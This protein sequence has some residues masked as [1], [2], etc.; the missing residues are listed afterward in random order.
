MKMGIGMQVENHTSRDSRE[1]KKFELRKSLGEGA[2]SPSLLILPESFSADFLNGIPENVIV[3]TFKACALGPGEDLSVAN[4]LSV[5]KKNCDER[6]CCAL[7]PSKVPTALGRVCLTIL[8][9]SSPHLSPPQPTL[10]TFQF[11]CGPRL[12]FL[13]TQ[14]PGPPF[15]LPGSDSAGIKDC[16][17][18]PQ[19]FVCPCGLCSLTF[20]TRASGDFPQIFPHSNKENSVTNC[21]YF[22]FKIIYVSCHVGGREKEP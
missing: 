13:K 1:H 21:W 17:S 16:R 18:S 11:G 12:E 7:S 2:L 10:K 19:T 9:L 22:S 20:P 3:T 14:W 5:V 15:S 4:R 6:L 8:T